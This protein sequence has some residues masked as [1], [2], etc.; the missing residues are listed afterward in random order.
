MQLNYK[1]LHYFWVTAQESS[2]TRAAER[3]HV[4]PQTICSQ[5]QA[6]EERLGVK[7]LQR[8]GRGLTVTDTGRTVFRYAD[9]IFSLGEEMAEVVRRQ[10]TVEPR[11]FHVGVT[12]FLPKLMAYR[13]L[14]PLLML[15]EPFRI[16]CHEGGMA[17]LAAGLAARRLDLVLSDRPLTSESPVRAES[18]RLGSCGVSFLARGDLV[19]RHRRGFPRSLDGAPMLMATADAVIRGRLLGW[20]ETLGIHPQVVA[21]FDDSALMKVFGQAGV[22]IFCAPT[23][24]EAE[25]CRQHQVEVVGRTREVEECFYAISLTQRSSHPAIQ[26][27]SQA[28]LETGA[29]PE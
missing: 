16:H 27:I 12:D 14:R 17:Q 8:E 29:P 18:R 3:L 6:L 2:L 11:H 28:V 22:G 24:V 25:I 13:L 23:L 15:E 1:H 26:V 10:V 7:L 19:R 20:F 5:I 9:R 4:T 21:E